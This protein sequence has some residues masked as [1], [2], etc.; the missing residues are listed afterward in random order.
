[1][2]SALTRASALLMKMDG[3]DRQKPNSRRC[4]FSCARAPTWFFPVFRHISRLLI[5]IE[6]AS[7]AQGE[8]GCSLSL[9]NGWEI[10]SG[11]NFS[12]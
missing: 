8:R 4:S 3:A 9:G 11:V 7:G 5:I 2:C 10:N 6:L 12:Q 1:M